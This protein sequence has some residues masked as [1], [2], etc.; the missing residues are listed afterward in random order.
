LRGFT[1]PELSSLVRDSTGVS[2]HMFT[3]MFWRIG[4]VWK[5]HGHERGF[6]AGQG[7]R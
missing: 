4:A 6:K 3:G 7:V 5:V 1:V 2:P